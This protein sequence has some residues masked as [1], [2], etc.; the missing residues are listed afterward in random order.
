M[1]DHGNL[2][3]EVVDHDDFAVVLGC[4]NARTVGNANKKV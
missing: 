4:N 3:F 2:E 1:K